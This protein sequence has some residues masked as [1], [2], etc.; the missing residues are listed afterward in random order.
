MNGIRL[1]RL[2]A[3]ALLVLTCLSACGWDD[4]LREYLDARF[5]QPFAKWTS[6]FSI[7]DVKRISV[8][9]AGMTA[10]EVDS[11]LQRARTAYQ[12]FLGGNQQL[13][14]AREAVAAAGADP[15]LGASDRE[16]LDLIDA[17]IEMRAGE[18]DD[19]EQLGRAKTKLQAFLRR[20]RNPAFASEARGWLARV[21]YL[22]G[23]QA[24]AGKIYLDELNRR[25]SN[26]SRETL[27]NSLHIVYRYDGGPQLRAQLDRYFDTPE[28]AAFAIELATNPHWNRYDPQTEAARETPS[29]YPRIRKLLEQHHALLSSGTLALLAM[30]TALR[31]GDPAGARKIADE[32]PENAPIRSDPDFNWMAGAAAYLSH[33]YAAAEAPL[34][35]LFRS[36]KA[37]RDQKAAAA[38]G[39]CGVYWKTGNVTERIRYA[40]WLHTFDRK[41][42]LGLSSGGEINDYSVYWNCSGWD[43]GML[44]DAE[45]PIE[46]LKQFV[47]SNPKLDDI[48]LIQY[49]MAVRLTREDRYEDAASIYQEIHAIVRAPRTRRLA[50]LYSGVNRRGLTDTDIWE[51]KV[52]LAQFLSENENRIY[53][54]DTLWSGFQRHAFQASERGDTTQEERES[55]A[56]L[57]RK[58]KDEQEEYWRAHL[59]LRDVVREAGRSKIGMRAAALEVACL[60]RI[61]TDRFGRKEEIREADLEISRWLQG[62]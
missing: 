21:N 42:Q 18:P 44:L 8:P 25:G 3:G 57:E 51:A 37:A 47:V 16:E 6:S 54:N 19:R 33:D 15:T 11:P 49:A 31:A 59:I 26:L 58:L 48:R 38:Y 36:P 60:R 7:P 30:R 41:E 45:A 61:D 9:Y 28:H 22:S 20:T 17:K 13:K 4:T 24:A 53:Y 46:T 1:L 35:A 32:V 12:Q 39:L 29:L 62:R 55:L 56:T 27:L 52:R 40:L 23:D 34:L 10:A 2:A 14:A 5:W 43:L 50:T